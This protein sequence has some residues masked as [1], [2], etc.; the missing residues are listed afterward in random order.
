MSGGIDSLVAAALLKEQ[1]KRIIGVHFLNGYET[2][3]NA[4][5]AM[6]H[7]RRTMQPLAEQLDISIHIIDLCAEF[8]RLVV[9]YFIHTYRSGKTPNPCLV[10]NPSIK[11]DILMNEAK[12]WGATCL[13]TGHY[14]RI[15]QRKDGRYRLLRG[16]DPHKDQSYFLARLTQVHL[17][18]ALFPLGDLTKTQT[19]RIA[20]RKGLEPITIEESQD[21]C[22]IR[23]SNYGDFLAAQPGFPQGE[24]PIEAIDGRVIGKHRGLHRYTVGQRRGLNCPSTEPYYVVRLDPAR[25][26]LVVGR[27]SDLLTNA[28]R[29]EHINWIDTP[30]EG[31]ISVTTRIRYRHKAV[32]TKVHPLD[33]TRAEVFFETPETAVTPGQGAV[34]YRGEEVL[35]GGWIV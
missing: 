22:F 32:P 8:K 35:G 23:N 19:R 18:S 26:R 1:G 10:C 25:N 27:K 13:A 17:A 7:A 4:A 33:V 14:A 16:Q 31:P 30:P 11:F 3:E 9:D 24:G 15:A 34:F 21:V 2:I 28:C 29:V 5:D 12:K 20:H 6:A